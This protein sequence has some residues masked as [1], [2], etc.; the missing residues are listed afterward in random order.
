AYYQALRRRAGVLVARCDLPS[1]RLIERAGLTISVTGTATLEAFL[2]GR[3]SL[4]LGHSFIVEY[5]GG[6]CS[7][8][9]LPERIRR[10]FNSCPSDE[11]VIA[12]L[13]EIFS[14]RYPCVFR[15]ADEEGS[16]ATRPEN[17]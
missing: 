11:R 12:G 8:Q 1:L 9:E 10:T 15:P 3:P 5:L 4:V 7:L 2:L 6:V 17:I 14:V 16:N 13:A